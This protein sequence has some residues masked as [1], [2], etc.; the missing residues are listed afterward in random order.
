MCVAFVQGLCEFPSLTATSRA[1][2]SISIYPLDVGSLVGFGDRDRRRRD[3]SRR[4]DFSGV[5]GPSFARL[6][7][8]GGWPLKVFGDGS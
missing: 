2:T 1:P 6:R 8:P 4:S 3:L 5:G 7:P